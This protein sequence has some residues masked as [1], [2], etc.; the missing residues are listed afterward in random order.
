MI[1]RGVSLHQFCNHLTRAVL[2]RGSNSRFK[3]SK[4]GSS[5]TALVL[6]Q[7]KSDGLAVAMH[8]QQFYVEPITDLKLP[9]SSFE[10][11]PKKHSGEKN[12]LVE[13][14]FKDQ[15]AYQN[16]AKRYFHSSEVMGWK[17]TNRWFLGYGKVSISA[18]KFAQLVQNNEKKRF[19]R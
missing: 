1:G 2:H 19:I 18:E 9:F 11:V 16:F 3:S 12:D 8:K 10:Y 13:L 4:S 6:P 17:W 5:E 15:G 7:V 14:Y